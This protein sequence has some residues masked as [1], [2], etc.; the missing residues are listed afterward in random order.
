MSTAICDDDATNNATSTKVDA[1]IY[2]THNCTLLPMYKLY[3]VAASHS[4]LR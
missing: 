4:N 3:A 1:A 2:I